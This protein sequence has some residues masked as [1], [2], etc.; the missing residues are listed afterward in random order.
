MQSHSALHTLGFTPAGLIES[1]VQVAFSPPQSMKL[2]NNG[3][4][5]LNP[6]L[7]MSSHSAALEGPSGHMGAKTAAQRVMQLALAD[8]FVPLGTQAPPVPVDA[9]LEL[10][11]AVVVVVVPLPLVVALAV[12]LDLVDVVVVVVVFEALL[13]PAPPAPVPLSPH[14]TRAS[15]AMATGMKVLRRRE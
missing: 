7:Q 12:E 4:M 8:E 11:A 3:H 6:L 10:D 2:S 14:P 13:P 1:H 9:E 15:A 5:V